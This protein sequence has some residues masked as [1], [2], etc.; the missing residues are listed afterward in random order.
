MVTTPHCDQRVLHAPGEC[1][2][3]DEYPAWQAARKMWGIAYTGHTITVAQPLP[4]PSELARDLSV[5]EAWGGNLPTNPRRT[6]RPTIP[7]TDDGILA[8]RSADATTDATT[9]ITFADGQVG[10]LS[11]LGRPNIPALR[12]DIEALV[13]DIVTDILREDAARKERSNE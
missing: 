9:P 12:R 10:P 13:R 8:H 1:E 6:A 5:I 7:P 11:Q 4:C 2:Y 3:C